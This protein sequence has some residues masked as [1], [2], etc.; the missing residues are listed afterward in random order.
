MNQLK[1]HHKLSIL[2]S[3]LVWKK[4][5]IIILQLSAKLDNVLQITIVWIT[6]QIN[7]I[8]NGLLSPS[9]CDETS[10]NSLAY[11]YNS[12]MYGKAI[13]YVSSWENL[14]FFPFRNIRVLQAKNLLFEGIF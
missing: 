9:H 4:I 14:L 13:I 7:L 11:I 2:L 10:I 3:N 6:L 12:H 5:K 8:C 1:K